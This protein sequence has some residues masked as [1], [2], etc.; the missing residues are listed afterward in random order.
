[1]QSQF[2]IRRKRGFRQKRRQWCA[3]KS[4]NWNGI[5]AATEAE[6][7]KTQ[8]LPYKLWRKPRLA[9]TLIWPSETDLGNLSRQ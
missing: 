2:V 7:V 1:M 6:N 3:Y 5:L 4:R 8:S 9:N